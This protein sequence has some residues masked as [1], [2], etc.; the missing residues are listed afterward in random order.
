MN[1]AL[2]DYANAVAMKVAEHI[3]RLHELNP[4]ARWR[5]F[6]LIKSDIVTSMKRAIELAEIV[7]PQAN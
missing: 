5:L 1:E 3:G 2:G 4:S 6:C 7:R